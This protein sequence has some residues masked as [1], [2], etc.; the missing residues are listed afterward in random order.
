MAETVPRVSWKKW[1]LFGMLGCFAFLILFVLA[2]RITVHE[3]FG[4]IASSRASALSSVGDWDLR[5]MWSSGWAGPMLQKGAGGEQWIA[6]SAD[7]RTRSSSFEQS[8]DRLHKIVGSHRGYF[9]DLRTE[10][11]ALG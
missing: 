3:L 2:L 8:V 9:E 6:R 4:G 1:L 11:R 7:L 10:S 5:S